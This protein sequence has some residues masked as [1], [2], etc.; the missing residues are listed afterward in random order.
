MVSTDFLVS[1]TYWPNLWQRGFPNHS[2]TT[3]DNNNTEYQIVEFRFAPVRPSLKR[4]YFKLQIINEISPF[5]SDHD[6]E[7]A[8]EWRL[9]SDV[10]DEMGATIYDQHV[11]SM[12]SLNDKNVNPKLKFWDVNHVWI[13]FLKLF[14][15][16]WPL[17][18]YM[19][20]RRAYFQQVLKEF[21]ED[22][23]QYVEIRAGI[24]EV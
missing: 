10:R 18:S 7:E 8:K 19:P 5:D 24:S 9:V 14:S 4:K 11:R 3:A 6:N 1:L 17:L 2:H 20:A 12:F 21:Y 23:V 16:V 22:G 15:N 13:D